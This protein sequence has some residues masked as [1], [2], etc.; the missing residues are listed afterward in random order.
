MSIS[1]R[2]TG[3]ERVLGSE[4]KVQRC[5]APNQDWVEEGF[6]RLTPEVI[7]IAVHARM[8]ER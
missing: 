5:E 8:P 3:V 2:V 4:F 1:M 6:D 7:R